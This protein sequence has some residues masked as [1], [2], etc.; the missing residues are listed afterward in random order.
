MG[1]LDRRH[2]WST[3]RVR[4]EFITGGGMGKVDRSLH[5][6]L[7]PINIHYGL[8]VLFTQKS[9]LY[10]LWFHL[11]S[12]FLYNLNPVENRTSLNSRMKWWELVSRYLRVEYL[13]LYIR[14]KMERW[15]DE[16]NMKVL[17]KFW[18]PEIFNYNTTTHWNGSRGKGF[19]L[20][21]NQDSR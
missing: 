16:Y 5:V 19:V 8:W 7:P 12:S 17:F 3:S 18:V 13:G 4:E 21:L 10:E 9:S 14:E 2:N 6:K 20:D 15:T 1:L 11:W